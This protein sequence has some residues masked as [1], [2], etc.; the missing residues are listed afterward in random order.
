MPLLDHLAWADRDKMTQVLMNLVG[1][2]V[3]FT[4]AGGKIELGT[5]EQIDS[6]WLCVYVSDTGPGIAPQDAARIF[7]EFYQIHEPGKEKSKGVGLGLPISKKIVEM[8][9]GT[10]TVTSK[11][12]SGS[13]FSFTLP[14]QG[15]H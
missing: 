12:G 6:S 1:N 7:D 5:E 15:H 10:I 14:A 9:G 3:K 13:R 4:P 8:H 2:A 11:V